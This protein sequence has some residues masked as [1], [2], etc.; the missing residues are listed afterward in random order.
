MVRRQAI[1]SVTVEQCITHIF[2]RKEWIGLV[3][4]LRRLNLLQH[5]QQKLI[6]ILR[7]GIHQPR[8]EL[9]KEGIDPVLFNILIRVS[10]RVAHGHVFVT[11]LPETLFDDDPLWRTSIKNQDL[12]GK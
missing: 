4:T 5:P 10:P 8:A 1:R 2:I 3:C 6:G 11:L 7:P 9:L 12:F